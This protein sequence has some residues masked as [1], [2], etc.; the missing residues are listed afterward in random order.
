M[1]RCP[2]TDDVGVAHAT[3]NRNLKLAKK[4]TSLIPC[5]L[6]GCLDAERIPRDLDWCGLE[7]ALERPLQVLRPGA[8]LPGGFIGASKSTL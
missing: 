8:A 1:S 4:K 6:L 2:D 7:F 3:K 5:Q